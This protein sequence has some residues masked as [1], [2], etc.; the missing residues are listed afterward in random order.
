MRQRD[1]VMLHRVYDRIPP[2]SILMVWMGRVGVQCMGILGKANWNHPMQPPCQGTAAA[3]RGTV[4]QLRSQGLDL[5]ADFH[6]S[7]YPYIYA[8]IYAAACTICAFASSKPFI[9]SVT[10]LQC[11]PNNLTVVHYPAFS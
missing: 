7:I 6:I 9:R 5:A 10:A 11:E 8:Y 3:Q 1:Q 4:P 2:K